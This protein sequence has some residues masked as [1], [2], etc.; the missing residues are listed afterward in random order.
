LKRNAQ[1][2][3]KLSKIDFKIEAHTG[4][5]ATTTVQTQPL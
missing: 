1:T 5:K 2:I 4:N 3:D